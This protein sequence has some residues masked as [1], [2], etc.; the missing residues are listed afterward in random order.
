[1]LIAVPGRA[2]RFRWQYEHTAMEELRKE[3]R[4]RDGWRPATGCRAGVPSMVM[5]TTRPARRARWGGRIW[6]PARPSSQ[7]SGRSRRRSGE[8]S[9]P[10]SIPAT[11]TGMSRLLAFP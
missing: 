1:M 8:Q 6:A 10:R 7:A 4:A 3:V 5:T 11:V 9:R 2:A